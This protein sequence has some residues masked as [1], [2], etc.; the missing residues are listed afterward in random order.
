MG[1]RGMNDE[2]DRKDRERKLV[3]M[4]S[5]E[6]ARGVNKAFGRGVQEQANRQGLFLALILVMVI[7]FAVYRFFVGP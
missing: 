2:I 4:T 1:G 5:D 7:G 3:K 6:F